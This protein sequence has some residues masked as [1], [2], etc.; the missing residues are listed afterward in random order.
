MALYNT[1]LVIYLGLSGQVPF[2]NGIDASR[3]DK[4]D[5]CRVSLES[6]SLR[7]RPPETGYGPQNMGLDRATSPDKDPHFFRD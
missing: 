7:A 1:V 6:N 2:R 5:T 4:T 3:F